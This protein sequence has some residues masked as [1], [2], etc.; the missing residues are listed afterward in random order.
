MFRSWVH[1]NSLRGILWE[2]IFS[3][4]ELLIL[5]M[6]FYMDVNSFKRWCLCFLTPMILFIHSAS[7]VRYSCI[8]WV[9]SNQVLTVNFPSL[10]QLE[11]LIIICWGV[12]FCSASLQQLRRFLA[13]ETYFL[14]HLNSLEIS[15]M[16]VPCFRIL[17]LICSMRPLPLVL[18]HS[19]MCNLILR[20]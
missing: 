1:S 13:M 12:F 7:W 19:R 9:F 10:V 11:L 16:N 2:V 5:S 4:I 3:C 14:G 6:Y 20:D 8:T 15:L 17:P 18:E